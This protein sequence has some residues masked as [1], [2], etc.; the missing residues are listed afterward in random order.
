[1]SSGSQCHGLLVITEPQAAVWP[2]CQAELYNPRVNKNFLF[3]CGVVQAK[4]GR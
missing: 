3:R 2:G 1:M 4:L